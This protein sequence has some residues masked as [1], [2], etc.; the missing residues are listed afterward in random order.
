MKIRNK[1]TNEIFFVLGY[2]SESYLFTYLEHTESWGGFNWWFRKDFELIDNET[3]FYEPEELDEKGLKFTGNFMIPE[4][5]RLNLREISNNV[6]EVHLFWD[7]EWTNPTLPA[8]AYLE[9]TF[10]KYSLFTP[11]LQD[12]I[13]SSF[14]LQCKNYLQGYIE[15]I[16]D[17]T[18]DK[19]G[20]YLIQINYQEREER[21]QITK[22]NWES[23]LTKEMIKIGHPKLGEPVVM[24][25]I[26]QHLK[27]LMNFEDCDY[28]LRYSN[29]SNAYYLNFE[30]VSSKKNV[31]IEIEVGLP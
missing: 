1:K 20:E 13:K 18:E 26:I 6:E 28:L 22:T 16:F 17:I 21:I 8:I 2:N 19:V 30:L 15:S 27:A 23:F 24:R 3:S 11:Y 4:L 7:C 12:Y 5:K 14:G 29:F 25:K 31:K 10:R 9:K